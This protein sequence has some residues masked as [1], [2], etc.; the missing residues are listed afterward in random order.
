LLLLCGLKL[1]SL[2]GTCNAGVTLCAPAC[3]FEF[4]SCLLVSLTFVRQHALLSMWHSQSPR[5]TSQSCHT[6]CAIVCGYCGGCRNCRKTFQTAAAVSL[7]PFGLCSH[8]RS[9][10][11]RN[12][13]C[14]P[15][16]IAGIS[17]HSA[18]R[19]TVRGAMPSHFATAAVV[20]SGS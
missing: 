19:Q 12:L 4:V 11:S 7:V 3:A 8:S 9:S 14:R 6:L 17:L 2:L 16:L 5:A 1:S 10:L 13:H 15:I 18:H 20:R